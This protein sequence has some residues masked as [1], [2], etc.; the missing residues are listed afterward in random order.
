MRDEPCSQ[1][2]NKTLI[3]HFSVLSWVH[4]C[5]YY[6]LKMLLWHIL[7]FSHE[8]QFLL[9]DINSVCDLT[10]CLTHLSFLNIHSDARNKPIHLSS[11]VIIQE[12][13]AWVRVD[14]RSEYGHMM[15]SKLLLTLFPIKCC[16]SRNKKFKK[17]LDIRFLLIFICRKLDAY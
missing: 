13:Q 4:L 7:M 9:L 8:I 1:W 11:T 5:P 3:M 10:F 17:V 14:D 12:P 2:Y 15:S 6:I 16:Y